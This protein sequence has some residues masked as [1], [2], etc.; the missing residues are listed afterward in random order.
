MSQIGDYTILTLTIPQTPAYPKPT[1]HTIYIR[2]HT[3]KIP[4]PD[5]AR[6]LFLVNIPIDSTVAHLRA[7][8]SSLLGAGKFES[9]SFEHE[10]RS[11]TNEGILVQK[12]AS[13]AGSKKRKRNQASN[14][15]VEAGETVELPQIWDRELRRSGST[16]VVVLVDEKS[17]ELTL[18]T[19][20]KL[21]KKASKSKGKEKEKG[22]EDHWPIWGKGVPESEKITGSQRYALHNKLRFPDANELQR[23]VDAFMTAFNAREEEKAQS[24]KRARNMP[25]EDGFIT[26]TRGGRTGPARAEEVERKRLEM[27][28]KEKKKR[29]EMGDFYRFQMREKRKE[30][31]GEMVKRF[32]EDR[33]KVEALKAGRRG[34]FV[35]EK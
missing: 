26:V 13:A 20:R 30:I 3:P 15:E 22:G 16:A 9:C 29:D 11:S 14:G 10:K 34:K 33:R 32:E 6:S 25:D 7:V 31:Q 1:T 28:E 21:H 2:P 23:N 19:I 18:K 12:A 5:D 8:F 35:P 27:E 4:T 24:A 17:V